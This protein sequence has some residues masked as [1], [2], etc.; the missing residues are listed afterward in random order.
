M[1][2]SV[3]VCKAAAAVGLAGSLLL[4]A[5]GGGEPPRGC[6]RHVRFVNEGPQP[7]AELYVS[8]VGADDWGN[9]RLGLDYLAPGEGVPVAVEDRNESCRADIRI[10]RD[11]GSERIGRGVAI[12]GAAGRRV[13][14]R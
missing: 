10:V 11:D 3:A 5:P 12:C 2:K 4:L 7:I 8:A 14:L 13:G 6:A 1:F 9:D